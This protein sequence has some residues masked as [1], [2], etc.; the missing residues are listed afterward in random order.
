ML[1]SL[2]VAIALAFS[3][4]ERNGGRV[5]GRAV[6]RTNPRNPTAPQRYVAPFDIIRVHACVCVCVFCV[7]V[8]YFVYVLCVLC[9]FVYALCV[10][11]VCVCV[12]VCVPVC[13]EGGGGGGVR[14]R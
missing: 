3:E 12:Y 4:T 10:Y 11:W 7:R 6:T 14:R 2:E 1:P 13:V 9:V 8:C 5:L